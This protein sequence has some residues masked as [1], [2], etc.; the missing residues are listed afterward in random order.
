M[1][2][3]LKK[4]IAIS[5][6]FAL[7][8]CA[9][10]AVAL[11]A[12]MLS[13][14]V[15]DNIFG[16][17]KTT[18]EQTE[19]KDFQNKTIRVLLSNKGIFDQKEFVFSSDSEMFVKANGS[20]V[21]NSSSPIKIT[22]DEEYL[23]LETQGIIQKIP[24]N[25]K[26]IIQT[27]SSP[28]RIEG[29]KK[30]GKNAAYKGS[31]EV[32]SAKGTSLRVINI[33]DIEDYIKGVVPNEM[34]TYFG[35]EALKAQAISARGYAYRDA[36]FKT[37]GY[38]VCDTTGS[39]VYNG[40]NSYDAVSDKAIDETMGQF[41]LYNGKIILSLYS[42]TSGG[43]TENYENTFSQNGTDIKFPAEPIPYLKG[44]PDID[45]NLDL[46]RE[47]NAKDFYTQKPDSFETASP[48]Y[49]WEYTYT[50]EEL[51]EILKKNLAKFSKSPF[52]KPSLTNTN[53]F[54]NLI[55]IDIPKRGVSGKAMYARITTDR[56]TFLIAKEIM[57]RQIFTYKNSW[58]PSA[59]II[60]ERIED[61]HNLV[62]FK[63]YG[64]GFGHGVGLSQYG[65]MGMAKRGYTYDQI[66][67][68]YYSGISIGSYPVECNLKELK[69]CK[70]TFYAP[71][72]NATLILNYPQKPHDITFKINGHEVA[73]SANKLSKN[74]GE[75]DLR[76][77]IKKGINTIE[78]SSYDTGILDFSNPSIKFYA[79][80][81]TNNEK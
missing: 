42:S 68:H 54:G 71:D 13:L 63:I 78:V 16:K 39:Q 43:H 34:P 12:E 64:G 4:N 19:I 49:R 58:L 62:G 72:K 14:P 29:F 41:A 36:T 23:L 50:K 25:Q 81:G 47:A 2:N 74:Q 69:N 10:F 60:I 77:W 35:L 33:I 7:F 40:A 59:N 5:A 28:I 51:T 75:A 67:K 48:K 70:S 31:L 11:D 45:E 38:D 73:I 46:T 56:T 37:T 20:F 53:D 55:D 15:L 24:S 26:I 52:V 61:G 9:N 6:I 1:Y 32:F 21:T 80:L 3:L 79:E 66:L 65:A 76:K 22:K 57:I 18:E 30:G 27:N 17:P 44:V 8:T